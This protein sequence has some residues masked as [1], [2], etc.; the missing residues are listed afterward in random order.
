MAVIVTC[1]DVP[2]PSSSGLGTFTISPTNST[3]GRHLGFERDYNSHSA[4]QGVLYHC[5]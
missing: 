5:A 3:A 4:F 2:G 1:S